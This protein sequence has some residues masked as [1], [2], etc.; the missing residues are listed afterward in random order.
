MSAQACWSHAK[1]QAPSGCKLPRGSDRC[2]VHRHGAAQRPFGDD[3][4]ASGQSADCQRARA[5]E[6][7]CCGSA[8]PSWWVKRRKGTSY[9]TVGGS[10]QGHCVESRRRALEKKEKAAKIIS[11]SAT[12][13]P[14][15][16][17]KIGCYTSQVFLYECFKNIDSHLNTSIQ[18]GKE[19]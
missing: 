10:P 6:E 12:C 13:F 16:G 14:N 9:E 5:E 1:A 2:H 15:L 17:I 7:S 18:K 11:V 8:W 19:I 3:G 4:R